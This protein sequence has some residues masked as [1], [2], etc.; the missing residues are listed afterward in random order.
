M[1]TTTLW[2]LTQEVGQSIQGVQ[3]EEEEA[4]LSIRGPREDVPLHDPIDELANVSLDGTT[5]LTPEVD[6]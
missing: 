2:R 6:S 1:S 3:E 5:V 4:G